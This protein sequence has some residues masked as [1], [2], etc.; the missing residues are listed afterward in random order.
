M[1]GQQLEEK[2]EGAELPVGGRYLIEARPFEVAPG[3]G[4]GGGAVAHFDQVAAQ[5]QLEGEAHEEGDGRDD[6]DREP[7][8]AR[9][10]T[11]G[12]EECDREVDRPDGVTGGERGGNAAN[13]DAG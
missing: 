9:R 2:L 10:A 3:R 8:Q 12:A 4:G 1:P 11:E 5:A 6:R 7:G 13:E